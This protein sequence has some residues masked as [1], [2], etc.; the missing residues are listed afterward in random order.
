MVEWVRRCPPYEQKQDVFAVSINTGFAVAPSPKW[1]STILVTCRSDHKGHLRMARTLA[2]DMWGHLAQGGRLL[3]LKM[4]EKTVRRQKG[5]RCC[6]RA[7]DRHRIFIP[8][9]PAAGARAMRCWGKLLHS[10]VEADL[11]QAAFAEAAN[12]SA[13]RPEGDSVDGDR[14]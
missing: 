14:R 10:W 7:A 9:I 13:R 3:H 2:A 11:P 5:L 4:A 8:S 6:E 1:D 12:A